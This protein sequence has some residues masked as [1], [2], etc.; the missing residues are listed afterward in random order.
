MPHFHV[1]LSVL[2]HPNMMLVITVDHQDKKY[3]N[4]SC[5]RGTS[6]TK[7]S[8]GISPVSS[9][10][11]K[12]YWKD[13]VAVFTFSIFHKSRKSSERV[14]RY[15]SKDIIHSLLC[16]IQQSRCSSQDRSKDHLGLLNKYRMYPT[17]KSQGPF[18]QKF[19]LLNGFHRL[20]KWEFFIKLNKW[21]LW[22]R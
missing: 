9:I 14:W 10:N 2:L 13:L 16:L 15:S 12:L 20:C 21:K 11:P 8:T 22:P 17:P 5:H 4:V 18:Q 3:S 6:I 1:M 7:S 19:F